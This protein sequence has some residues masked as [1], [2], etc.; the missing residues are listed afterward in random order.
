[1]H[2]QKGSS[3]LKCDPNGDNVA[4]FMVINTPFQYTLIKQAEY[5]SKHIFFTQN[6][7]CGRQLY[8]HTYIE[9]KND[10]IFAKAV[11]IQ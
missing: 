6:K 3:G 9:I 1:M 2:V 7:G 8:F 4:K 11:L 10:F 5:D